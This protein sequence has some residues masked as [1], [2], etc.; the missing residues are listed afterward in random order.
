MFEGK[1]ATSSLLP[2]AEGAGGSGP[3]P[4]PR[5]MGVMLTHTSEGKVEAKAGGDDAQPDE[6]Q[7]AQVV[8]KGRASR[9]CS[10]WYVLAA[11]VGTA[12][13]LH[14]VDASNDAFSVFESS[15]GLKL[16]T[17]ATPLQLD[18]MQH[19]RA[20]V[21]GSVKAAVVGLAG[22]CVA[23]A[24][25]LA[26]HSD[27]VNAYPASAKRLASCAAESTCSRYLY[28]TAV[29]CTSLLAMLVAGQPG[30][31][32]ALPHIGG[33]RRSNAPAVPELGSCLLGAASPPWGELGHCRGDSWRRGRPTGCS[34]TA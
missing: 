20:A 30:Q 3:P 1:A 13:I 16:L 11:C 17:D 10:A 34:A 22:A 32:S 31:R 14:A 8:A 6:L 4:S 25:L 27:L 21:F 29:S 28:S 19:T 24:C 23:I 9:L 12:L 26:V 18:K 2:K 7:N 5:S 15:S 33:A